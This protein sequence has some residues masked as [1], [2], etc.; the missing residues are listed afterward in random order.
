MG[1]QGRTVNATVTMLSIVM[2]NSAHMLRAVGE[3]ND[4]SLDE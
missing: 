2:T 1:P 3:G 4:H